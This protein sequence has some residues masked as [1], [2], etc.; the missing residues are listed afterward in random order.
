VFHHLL[1]ERIDR[2]LYGVFTMFRILYAGVNSAPAL[3]V[4]GARI[5]RFGL[6]RSCVLVKSLSEVR[7]QK[8]E[9]PLLMAEE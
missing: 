6:R 8:D 7:S 3:R 9:D 2:T 4:P 1:L 5:I